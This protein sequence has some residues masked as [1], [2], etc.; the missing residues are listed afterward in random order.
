[1]AYTG[2]RE[3]SKYGANRWISSSIIHYIFETFCNLFGSCYAGSNLVA[4]ENFQWE[5][6]AETMMNNNHVGMMYSR[7]KAAKNVGFQSLMA[8]KMH[9]RRP[10]RPKTRW[11]GARIS[12][13]RKHKAGDIVLIRGYGMD[14]WYPIHKHDLNPK[15]IIMIRKLINLYQ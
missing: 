12:N 1:M 10:T 6:T 7:G 3:T 9:F 8:W 14:P 11:F 5:P 4:F 13:F 2:R 15:G